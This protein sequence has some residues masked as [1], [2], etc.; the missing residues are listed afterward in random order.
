VNIYD[1]VT[2]VL[3][4]SLPTPETVTKIEGSPDGFILYLA[5]SFS[6]TMHDVQTGGLAHTFTTES[7]INDVAV[8]PT[9]DHIACGLSNGTVMLWNIHTKEEG[10]GFGNSQSVVTISWLLPGVLVIATQ[11][12]LYFHNI[13]VDETWDSFTF[14][15]C[16][17]GMVHF[18][19]SKDKDSYQDWYWDKDEDEEGRFLVGTSQPGVGVG[20]ELCSFEVFRYKQANSSQHPKVTKVEQKRELQQGQSSMHLGQLTRPT[21]AGRSILCI[22]PPGGVKVFDIYTAGWTNNSSLLDA[23]TAVA[24][25]SSGN[26]VVQTK[27]SIQ[28]FSPD[29]VESRDTHDDAHRV[30]HAYPLGKNHII[31]VLQS[32][33]RLTLLDLDTIQ[34]IHPGD[35]TPSLESLLTNQSSSPRVST[36]R[37]LVAEF[38]ASVVMEAWRSHTPPPEW[39]SAADEDVPLGGLSP[40]C[41]RIV[42]VYGSPRRELRVKDC[43]DGNVLAKLPLEEGDFRA[44]EVYDLTFDSETRFRLKV[45]GPGKHVQIPYEI[46]ASPSG[47][48]SHTITKGESLQLSEPRAKPPYTLDADCE[49]VLDARSRKICWISP[50]DIR[51]GNGGHFWAGTSLVMVGEDGVVR[52]VSFEEPDF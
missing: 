47:Q 36:G 9:G 28:I 1:I 15:G 42:T 11:S 46:A 17:W 33:K 20:Q 26:L 34:E 31:C 7:E 21:L 2:G 25:S 13:N 30:S 39:T 4:Q 45:D 6:V 48:Y 18:V 44:G 23:A 12:S 37:G 50:R 51:K 8:S 41:T 32:T 3:Q 27:D 10:K 29:V 35:A 43:K 52:K 19:K 16:V 24:V 5:H 49:W 38:G 40:E 14:S 22:T